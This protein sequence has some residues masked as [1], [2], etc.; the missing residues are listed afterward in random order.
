MNKRTI[1]FLMGSLLLTGPAFAANEEANEPIALN[2]NQM[3]SVT[4]G[5]VSADATADAYAWSYGFS[6]TY[7]EA[8]TY[9]Y[10]GY[11]AS[12]GSYSFSYAD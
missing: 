5:Y 3:D 12:A 8:S 11:Y 4:A 10:G 9:A 2:E 1:G 7:A 6:H